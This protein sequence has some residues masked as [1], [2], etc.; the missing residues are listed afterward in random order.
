[1]A[2]ARAIFRCEERAAARVREPMCYRDA[3]R[4]ESPRAEK[5]CRVRRDAVRERSEANVTRARVMP[6]SS[7]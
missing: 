4:R 6:Y 3:C 7:S 1:M 5:L 2:V